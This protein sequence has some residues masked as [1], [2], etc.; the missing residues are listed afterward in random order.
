AGRS[1]HRAGDPGILPREHCAL[2]VPG[3]GG[4]RRPAQDLD[5]Q[6]AK[7]RPAR[8]GVGREGEADQLSGGR[9]VSTLAV[10]A[11][12]VSPRWFSHQTSYTLRTTAPS[13]TALDSRPFA[14]SVSPSKTG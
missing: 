2:Q 6:G 1:G 11:V 8:E 14:V 5:R 9:I 7:V 3:S 10:P 13:S 4:V 12:V